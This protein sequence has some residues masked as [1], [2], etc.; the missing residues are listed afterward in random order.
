[1]WMLVWKFDFSWPNC[2]LPLSVMVFH[3]SSHWLGLFHRSEKERWLKLLRGKKA[4]LIVIY[5]LTTSHRLV[6]I[7][8]SYRFGQHVKML[9]F[10]S[11]PFISN[12]PYGSQHST[13]H[14]G[15]E[16]SNLLRASASFSFHFHGNHKIVFVFRIKHVSEQRVRY[17]AVL[18]AVTYHCS[19]L[20]QAICYVSFFPF[21]FWGTSQ[22]SCFSTY[23][24]WRNYRKENMSETLDAVLSMHFA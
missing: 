5:F 19:N 4:L 21:I 18:R 2:P 17:P 10:N 23:L 15:E 9:N 3:L 16:T 24:T 12:T 20:I 22:E 14:P 6:V 13:E 8:F 11:I 7:P 1:M